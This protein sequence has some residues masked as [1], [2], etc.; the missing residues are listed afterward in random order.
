MATISLWEDYGK[1]SEVCGSTYERVQKGQ[2]FTYAPNRVAIYILACSTLH[3][4]H[5]ERRQAKQHLCS[6]LTKVNAIR[7]H[8]VN[9]NQEEWQKCVTFPCT[10]LTCSPL[11][12]FDAMHLWECET[13]CLKYWGSVVC[14]LEGKGASQLFWARIHCTHNNI[15]W[16]RCIFFFLLLFV[17]NSR[18]GTEGCFNSAIRLYLYDDH[19]MK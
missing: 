14:E 4:G 5:H 12:K 10:Q 6:S 16:H 13:L 11:S 9:V 18:A 19:P 2:Y 8:F 3:I 15:T 1:L 7:F 17:L